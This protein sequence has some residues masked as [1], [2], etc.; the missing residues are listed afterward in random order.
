MNEKPWMLPKGQTIWY[1]GQAI[2]PYHEIATLRAK[3]YEPKKIITKVFSPGQMIVLY[4]CQE[5]AII[6]NAEGV[7]IQCEAT[8]TPVSYV[9]VRA[10]NELTDKIEELDGQ[11]VASLRTRLHQAEAVIAQFVYPGSPMTPQQHEAFAAWQAA[12][13]K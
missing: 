3:V 6:S 7:C 1:E 2:D 4:E 5:H 9:L 10:C 13:E 11:V 12:R 8:L